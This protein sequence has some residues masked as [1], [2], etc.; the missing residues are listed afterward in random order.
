MEP[1]K[2]AGS[3]PSQ[4]SRVGAGQVMRL[5]DQLIPSVPLAPLLGVSSDGPAGLMVVVEGDGAPVGLL[6]DELMGQQQVVVKS[7]E[8]NYGPVKGV[9]GATILGDGSVSFILEVGGLTRSA[10]LAGEAA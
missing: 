9:Q 10:S 3:E 1:V 7:L 5:R 4:L 8:T 2:A 6:V